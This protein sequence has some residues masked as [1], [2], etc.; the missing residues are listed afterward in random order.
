MRAA[1]GLVVAAATAAVVV[2][3]AGAEECYGLEAARVCVTPN[4]VP[5][6][7]PTGSSIDECVHVGSSCTPVTVPVPSVSSKPRQPIV[8]TGCY[9]GD[10]DCVDWVERWLPTTEARP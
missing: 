3:V 5:V 9:V 1:I 7:H 8:Y 10:E 4:N 6:V 2:T